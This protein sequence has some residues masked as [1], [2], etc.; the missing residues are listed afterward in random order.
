MRTF[1]RRKLLLGGALGAG[2]AAALYSGG[3][4]YF[5]VRE[6]DPTDI[7]LAV[8]RKHTARLI[9]RDEDLVAFAEAI[10]ERHTHSATLA[11]MGMLGPVY[12][13]LDIFHLTREMRGKMRR[14]EDEV[15]GEF[16][17]STDFFY[18]GADET[19][20]LRYLGVFDPYERQCMNP[21]VE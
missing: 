14:F 10:R 19:R 8:L 9:V 11:W 16:L 13:R 17:L 3:W 5:K 7:I 21:F 18:R 1:G 4:W 6:P 12:R 20:E 2:A 15:V